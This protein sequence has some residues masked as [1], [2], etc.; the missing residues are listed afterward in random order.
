MLGQ[1]EQQAATA[2]MQTT[3]LAMEHVDS[4]MAVANTFSSQ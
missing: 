4:T 3:T 2:V 1:F